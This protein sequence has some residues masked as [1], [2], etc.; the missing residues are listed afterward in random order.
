MKDNFALTF[1]RLFDITA[2]IFGLIV[3][4]PI[5]LGIAILIKLKMPGPIFFRQNRVG[6]D[7]K[8]FCMVKFRTMKVNHGG[9]TISVKGESRIT[10]LGATM[11]KYKLDELPEFWNILTGDMSFVGPRPDVPGYA[12]ILKGD[13]RLLLTIRPGLTG[14]AS[15]K[16]SNEEELLSEQED[17]IKFNDEV[18]YPAKV[19]INN[20]YVKNWSFFLDIKII[21]YTLLGK[22]LEDDWAN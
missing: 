7:A 15:I 22:S 4:S 5:F 9:S 6:K 20:N 1:K 10:P 13:D 21:I 3:F 2:S 18:L 11:R 14:A 12:D 19:R 8:L 16:Y 17:P